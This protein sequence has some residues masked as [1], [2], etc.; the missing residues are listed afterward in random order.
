LEK[1]DLTFYYE[2]DSIRTNLYN[3]FNGFYGTE[4]NQNAVTQDKEGNFWFGTINGAVK[5]F[6]EKDNSSSKPPR[7]EI[8]R[9]NVKGKRTDWNSSGLDLDDAGLP[10][11]LELT[12]KENSLQLEFIGVDLLEPDALTYS[13]ILVGAEDEWS[14]YQEQRSVFYSNLAPGDYAFMVRSKDQNTG[15][16][17]EPSVYEFSIIP[18]YYQTLWFKVSLISLISLGFFAFFF[19][20]VRS[21]RQHEAEQRDFQHQLAELEMTALRSQM[22][23]HF[24]FNSLNSVNNFII[25]NKKEEASEYLTKF[26]RLVRMVLQNSQEKLVSLE[27]ELTALRLYIQME[28]LRFKNDFHYVEKIDESIDLSRYFIPPLLLQPYVENAIWHGLLHLADRQG[29]L[30]LEL[31]QIE[32]GVKV[33]IKDNGVGR[34]KSQLMKSKTA[35]KKKSMGMKIN[36]DRMGLSKDLY[37]FNID[38]K[39]TD[40]KAS[41]GLAEGTMVTIIISENG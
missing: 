25:K 30:T 35:M 28:S 4:C 8:I 13:F 23:P 14:D 39:L 3:D 11:D 36:A 21:I 12:R 17:S 27:N 34:E 40:L 20:R 1:L 9:L 10:R 32:G 26:S 29:K 7:I 41:D 19:W 18:T 33:I 5:Y 15:L 16:E 31:H 24:L 6:P 38:I 37:D 2:Q 22:N